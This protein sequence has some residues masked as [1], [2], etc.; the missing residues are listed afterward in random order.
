MS[1]VQKIGSSAYT[2]EGEK[3][4]KKEN[5]G[6][7]RKK[8][9]R[10]N[11][12]EERERRI[13]RSRA[14]SEDLVVEMFK[15]TSKEPEAIRHKKKRVKILENNRRYNTR[16]SSSDKDLDDVFD[17]EEDMSDIERKLVRLRK[18]RNCVV[19]VPREDPETSEWMH[20]S[21]GLPRKGELVQVREDIGT[22]RIGTV[23]RLPR[24]GSTSKTMLLLEDGEWEPVRIDTDDIS[25]RKIDKK[26]KPF[27]PLLKCFKK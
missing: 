3:P 7:T 6:R 11:R 18:E 24:P 16:L 1:E 21:A 2:P 8:E 20:S 27:L 25:Y 12:V 26:F 14:N 13:T 5:E 19:E 9:R 17:E 23:H 15:G 4:K 22:L 10:S